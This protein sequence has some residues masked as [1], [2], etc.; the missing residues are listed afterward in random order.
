MRLLSRWTSRFSILLLLPSG[1]VA[2][3][4][5]KVEEL[6]AGA[7]VVGCPGG[8]GG[9]QLAGLPDHGRPGQAVCRDLAAEVDSGL[10]QT[11]RARRG[12]SSSPFSSQSELLG[13][14][15]LR[16]GRP[17][18]SRPGHRQGSVHDAVRSPAGQRRPS[19]SEPLSRLR[20]ALAGS[21]GQD[22]GRCCPASSSRPAAPSPRAPAIPRAS[23]CWPSPRPPRAAATMIHDAE[24][25]TWRVVVPLS[26]A[27]KGESKPLESTRVD[28]RGRRLRSGLST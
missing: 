16:G 9:P 6:E 1:L 27:V 2:Q 25:N 20:L 12:S 21:Q 22:A 10:V 4:S 8:R 23:S 15:Q 5:F 17:R 14:V 18:L 7:A 11:V 19:G 26:L 13:V 28:H 3:E 24:K